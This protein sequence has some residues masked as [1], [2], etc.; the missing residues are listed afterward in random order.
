M[1]YRICDDESEYGTRIFRE[2][3]SIAVP[4]RQPP[5]RASLPG[6]RDLPGQ[7]LPALRAVGQASWPVH[8]ALRAE[9][10]AYQAR[11]GHEPP[12][13]GANC[14]SGPE[15]SSG[16]P[17]PGKPSPPGSSRS[18]RP[19]AEVARV[20]DEISKLPPLV[21]S[22]EIRALRTQLAEAARG[23][24]FLLQGGDCAETLRP[25]RLRHHRQQAQD[26]AADEPGAGARRPSRVIRVGRFAGQYAKPRSDDFETRD[27]VTLPSYR[28]DL[29]NSPEFTEAARTPDPQLMLR[30]YERAALT[31][32]FIRALVSRGFADP[33]P[34]RVLGP[35]F[36]S[37][38]RPWPRSTGAWRGSIGESLRF[39]ESILGVHP[40]ELQWI[41]FFTSHEGLQLPYEQAQ[42]RR[43]PRREGWYNLSTHFPW[44]G[45]RTGRSGRRARGVLPGHSQS[46]SAVKV[47]PGDHA[48]RLL[49][50]DRHPP[51]GRRARPPHADSSLRRGEDRPR[52]CRR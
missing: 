39:M 50:A 32:N 10:R 22:W 4:R 46:R 20:V 37:H 13:N 45:M 8:G 35:R 28:G 21:T 1:Q 30:G 29:I 33:A 27:G 43:V 23:E 7:G 14:E 26:P 41:D 42:T 2:G 40:G 24:R 11:A 9:E 48:G 5:R 19:L 38:T 17:H 52:C 25:L 31:L 12:D 6:R 15:W 44:I 49:A 51:S 34:P 16:R 3:R 47:G 18:T 36:G